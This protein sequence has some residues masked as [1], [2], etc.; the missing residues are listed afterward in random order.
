MAECCFD[1]G[2]TQVDV[3]FQDLRRIQLDDTSWIDVAPGWLRGSDALFAELVH[4]WRWAQRDVHVRQEGPRAAPDCG[5]GYDVEARRSAAVR[6]M[7]ACCRSATASVRS[8]CFN[9]YRDGRDSVAWHGDRILH[10][11]QS[12]LVGT[13]SLGSVG[14]SCSDHAGDGPP[15]RSASVRGPPCHGRRLADWEHRVPKEA[16]ARGPR[17]SVTLR[18][19]AHLAP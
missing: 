1:G 18:H 7:S 13:V 8:I 6:D 2:P 11:H 4:A 3:S 12:P 14:G 19:S 15:R 16:R 17:I 9:L 10:T 5:L